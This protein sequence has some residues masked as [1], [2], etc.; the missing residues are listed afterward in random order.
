MALARTVIAAVPG[1]AMAFI[2]HLQTRRI[3]G[4]LQLFPNFGFDSHV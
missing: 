1:V 4:L 2:H 3:E